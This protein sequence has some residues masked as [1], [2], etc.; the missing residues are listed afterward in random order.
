MV[1]RILISLLWGFV[2]YFGACVV[3]VLIAGVR[4]GAE[5]PQN[6]A[7]AGAEAGAKAVEKL[8]AYFLI[9]GGA[10]ALVGILTGGLPGSGSKESSSDE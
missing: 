4:T 5:N 6:A 10:I 9:G 3:T 8:R 1:R 2:V 7:I